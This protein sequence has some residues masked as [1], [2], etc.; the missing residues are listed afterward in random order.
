MRR[1]LC[2][3]HSLR[4]IDLDVQRESLLISARIVLAQEK[5]QGALEHLK[6]ACNLV[7]SSRG[8]YGW[9]IFYSLQAAGFHEVGV[10]RAVLVNFN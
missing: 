7:K 8:S 5:H 4:H 2:T 1:I 6:S 10:E 9:P 3:P